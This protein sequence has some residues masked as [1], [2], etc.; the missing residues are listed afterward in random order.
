VWKTKLDERNDFI[1]K[2]GES[3]FNKICQTDEKFAKLKDL[4]FPKG[5]SWLFNHFYSIW[6]DCECDINGNKIFTPKQIMDYCLC[7]GIQMTFRER[8]EIMMI[9]EWAFEGISKVKAETDN[10]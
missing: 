5:C 3:E 1:K 6:K 10:D 9:K 4:D 7:F 8:Q 2:F